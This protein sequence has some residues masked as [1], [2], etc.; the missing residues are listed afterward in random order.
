MWP[1]LKTIS[2]TF[3]EVL[4]LY[5]LRAPAKPHLY[6]TDGEWFTKLLSDAGLSYDRSCLNSTI[7]DADI[8]AIINALMNNVYDR[9]HQ[10]YVWSV[11]IDS[12]ENHVL[13]ASN[14][15][16]YLDKVLNV[17]NLTLPRYIPLLIQNKKYSA[18]PVAP[19]ESHSNGITRFNDTP[20][21]SG[22]FSDDEHTSN[23]SQTESNQSVDVGSIMSRLDELFKNFRSILLEWSN[24]F[25]RVFLKEEQL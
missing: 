3:Q 10:D 12:D 1:M 4:N 7:S 8:K 20:Q 5:P 2:Y 23:I 16:F 21:D 17:L 19:I 14:I 13:D 15:A 11:T 24:E 18:D 6:A 9:H 22:D 25:N